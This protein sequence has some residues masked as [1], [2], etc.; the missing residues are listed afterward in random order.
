MN[1]TEAEQLA[2]D[3]LMGEWDVPEEDQE[4]FSVLSSRF[5][6][7]WYIVEIGVEGLPDKWFIQ[8]YDNGDCDPNYTFNSPITAAEGTA[9]LE[10]F[11]PPVAAMIAAERQA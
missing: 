5:K 6:D 8:V 3:F 11:P 7:S 1:A 9:E 2:I 4:W 10:E